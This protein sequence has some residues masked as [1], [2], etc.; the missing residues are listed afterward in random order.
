MGF[1]RALFDFSFSEF[2]T[3]RLIKLLYGIGV[4]L[5]AVAALVVV[6][7]GFSDSASVGVVALI[8]S[9]VVFLAFVILVRVYLELV[10][11][12]FRIAEHARDLARTQEIPVDSADGPERDRVR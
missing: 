5:A 2:V 9:P 8:L 3:T 1:L 6:V 4:L 7:G 12:V 10:I 11:V